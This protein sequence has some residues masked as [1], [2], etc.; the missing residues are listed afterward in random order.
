MSERGCMIPDC[1]GKF[2]AKGRCQKHYQ[3]ERYYRPRPA[4][5][6]KDLRWPDLSP[7]QEA[8]LCSLIRSLPGRGKP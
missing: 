2:F 5:N 4:L 8:N 7:S 6:S 1:E 3:E